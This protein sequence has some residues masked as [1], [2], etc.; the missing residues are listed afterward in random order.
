MSKVLSHDTP[1]F[2]GD[3]LEQEDI[4]QSLIEDIRQLQKD[5]VEAVNHNSIKFVSQN[6]QPTVESGRMYVWEDADATSGQPTH[7]IVVNTGTD[8]V[9][10]ASEE[11]V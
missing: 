8:T 9:T 1:S 11:T 2:R 5:I 4:I 3:G 6:G 7:Y 10:F